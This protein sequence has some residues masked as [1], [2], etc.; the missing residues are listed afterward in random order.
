[1]ADT[2]KVIYDLVDEMSGDLKKINNPIE[3]DYQTKVAAGF[4][5]S[6]FTRINSLLRNF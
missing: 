2:V 5:D 1:M 4:P 6:H 3:Q